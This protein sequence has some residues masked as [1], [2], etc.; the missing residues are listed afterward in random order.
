MDAVQ[1]KC[2]DWKDTGKKETMKKSL[3]YAAA[4]SLMT[5]QITGCSDVKDSS[6]D[7]AEESDVKMLTYGAEDLYCSIYDSD[8]NLIYSGTAESSL[9]PEETIYWYPCN[10]ENGFQSEEGIAVNVTVGTDSDALKTVGLTDGDSSDSTNKNPSAILHTGSLGYW[11]LFM[12]NHSSD[13]F[14]ITGVSL[15]MEP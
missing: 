7:T 13:T 8:G 11:K 1:V 4:V 2:I 10:D 9:H 14:K 12:I 5:V 6:K 3:L 15:S